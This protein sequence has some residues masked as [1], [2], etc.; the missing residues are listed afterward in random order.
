MTNKTVQ[1]IVGTHARWQ[2]IAAAARAALQ[3]G[4]GGIVTCGAGTYYYAVTRGGFHG[5]MLDWIAAVRTGTPTPAPA[6]TLDDE[7]IE[8][9]LEK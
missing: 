7:E 4:P 1:E 2:D 9:W 8:A 6:P 5:S 3:A